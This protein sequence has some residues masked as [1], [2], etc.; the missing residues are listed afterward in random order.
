M[1]K[2]QIVHSSSSLSKFF[3]VESSG[4]RLSIPVLKIKQQNNNIP[5]GGSPHKIF[6]I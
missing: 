4:S 3:K 5:K 2:F 1:K 6:I